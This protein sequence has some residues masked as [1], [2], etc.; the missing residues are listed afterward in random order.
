MQDFLIGQ[1][2]AARADLRMDNDTV[3]R[4][5]H[6]F[7]FTKSTLTVTE[8]EK[9]TFVIG[10]AAIPALPCG[11]EYAL[12]VNEAGAAVIGRDY[13]G[14]M[15]GYF[16]L[17]QRIEWRDDAG[18]LLIA[19][20]DERDAVLLENRMVHFC[21]F[22]ETPLLDLKKDIRLAAVLGYTHA[23]IEFWGMLRF[24]CE[25]ALAWDHAFS[26]EELR[27]VIR[28]IREL[29][30]EAIPML[31]HLGHATGCRLA[32]GKHVTLDQKPWLYP[33]FTPDGW[34]WNI[35]SERVWELLKAVRAELYELFG[36]GAYFHAGL[37]ESYMYANDPE[38][39]RCLPEFLGRL[40]EEIVKEGR[41]PMI[42]MDMFL[43]PEAYGKEK[44]HACGK[45]TAGDCR[46]V[47]GALAKETVLIDW[48]YDVKEAPVQSTLYLKDCGFDIMG[49]PW[50]DVQN[51]Y[52]HIETAQAHRLFGVMQTTWHTMAKEF[53]Y[54]LFFARR[55]GAPKAPW[56]DVSGYREEMATLLRKIVWEKKSYE[57]CGWMKRQIVL[58]TER[59]Y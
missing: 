3:K 5:L 10:D 34:S 43:P 35:D 56:S 4:M 42:W 13:G 54:M 48:H 46:A 55:L 17:L 44:V 26:K 39:Y 53:P 18:A 12:T 31:N 7:T 11:A 45:K 2:V 51:G 21:V 32:S 47:L 36:E 27:A 19:P 41:R 57:D 30:M 22:P 14:L 29:G 1:S 50:L 9:N 6:G 24:D 40:T 20:C 8:G 38:R 15:R 25:S 37:D 16:A 58:G 28:E 49:A 52:A 59:T 23:V 33:L